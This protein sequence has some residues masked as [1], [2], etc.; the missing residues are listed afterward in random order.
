MNCTFA[1]LAVLLATAAAAVADDK[2]PVKII[3][4]GQSFFEVVSSQGT[5]V[6]FDPQAI[7]A[8]GRIAIPHADLILMSHL[9]SD[10]TQVDVVDDYKKVK[11][12]N[13]LKDVKGDGRRIEFVP[14]DDSIKDVKF[15]NVSAYH[16]NAEGMIRGRNGIWV[17]EMDG[18]RIVHLGDLG[19]MLSDEQL[20]QIGP[21]D[22][23]M[24]PVGGVYTLN[25]TDAKK[26]I[27]QLKPKRCILPMHYGIPH[28]FEDLLP[29]DE[30][31]DGVKPQVIKRFDATNELTIDPASPAPLEPLI[32]ILSWKKPS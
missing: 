6:V 22:V 1:A 10:H 18:L 15:H 17:V 4:H 32:A 28:V 20:K 8:F 13:A 25:G 29:L 27:E 21:V 7:E 30:F 12:Y 2:P 11:T 3:W 26:V 24:I 5:R 23:L 31:L 16:D 14:V 9:H 19:H